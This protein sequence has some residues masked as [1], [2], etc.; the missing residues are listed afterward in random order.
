MFFEWSEWIC[1]AKCRE[2]FVLLRL[3]QDSYSMLDKEMSCCVSILLE[4]EFIYENGIFCPISPVSEF[5]NT[6]LN[7]VIKNLVSLRVISSTTNSVRRNYIAIQAEP[8]GITQRE[9]VTKI[10]DVKVQKFLVVKAYFYLCR[11]QFILKRNKLKGLIDALNRSLMGYHPSLSI[12]ESYLLAAALDSACLFFP[13]NIACLSYAASLF[14]LHSSQCL[15]C[16]FVIG[17]QTLPF[18]AHAWIEVGG[19]L[20]NDNP[21]LNRPVA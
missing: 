17:V 4:N 21:E 10:H 5:D 13:K 2:C 8:G 16:K 11:V 1:G 12:D 7:D 3:D 15:E 6:F 9:W 18:Y 20:I 19:V 14:M